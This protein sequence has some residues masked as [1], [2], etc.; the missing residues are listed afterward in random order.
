MNLISTIIVGGIVTFITPIIA[1]MASVL[2]QD[3]KR[4]R[5]YARL[6]KE[7]LMFV[8]AKIRY[9]YL[10][11]KEEPLISDVKVTSLQ[12]GRVEVTKF[13]KENSAVEVLCFTG[14]EYEKLHPVYDISD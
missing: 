13:D 11:G 12:K 10:E 1:A 2:T 14:Q 4:K 8:G 5:A 6:T 7:P 3:M 9:L